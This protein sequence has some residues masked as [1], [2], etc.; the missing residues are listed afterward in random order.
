MRPRAIRGANFRAADQ[1][2][3][4]GSST[5]AFTAV[6]AVEDAPSS[7]KVPSHTQLQTTARY[8]HLPTRRSRLERTGFPHRWPPHQRQTSLTFIS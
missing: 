5:F 4:V 8:P 6:A 1:G 2:K 7:G 3:S